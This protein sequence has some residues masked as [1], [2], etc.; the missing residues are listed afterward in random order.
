VPISGI[1]S[2][3]FDLAFTY[4]FRVCFGLLHEGEKYMMHML[5]AV[6]S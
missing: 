6:K 3:G 1:R 4:K 2:L 5:W